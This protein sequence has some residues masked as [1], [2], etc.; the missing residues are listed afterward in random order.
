[1]FEIV[2]FGTSASAPSIYRGLPSAAILAGEDRFLVDCGE[3]TQRQILRSGI[4]FKKLN[5]ILLTHAHLDHILGL[6]GLISTFTSWESMDDITIWGSQYALGRV[7]SL[8]FDVVFIGKKPS[9]PVNLVDVESG[10]IYEGKKFKVTAIPV[11]HRGAG[12]Y[13]YVFEE[14]THYPFISEKAD[15]LG[16]PFGPERSLLVKG[17]SV[18]LK[19][20]TVITPD[21]V[22][23]EAIRGVKVVFTGDIGNLEAIKEYA[24]DADILVT[25]ATFLDEH[26]AEAAAFGHITATQAAQFALDNNIKHLL[27]THLSRR[28]REYDVIK[29]AKSIFPNAIVARDLDHF[30]IRRGAALEKVDL[31]AGSN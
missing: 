25:E 6:G 5:R 28:Y 20:G 8:I 18:T 24:A 14:E 4:G 23:G 17:E 13:G 22:L 27:L 26:K 12:C 19:D 30:R 7:K 2:F 10:I 31:R 29:E 9:I 21:M 15:E 11:Q 1:M 3:G 16:V